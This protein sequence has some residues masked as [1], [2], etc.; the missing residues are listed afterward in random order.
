MVLSAVNHYAKFSPW[1]DAV[2]IVQLYYHK[3]TCIPIY[4]EISRNMFNSEY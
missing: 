4:D 1:S 2:R 3:I